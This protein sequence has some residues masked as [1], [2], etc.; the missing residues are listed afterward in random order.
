VSGPGGASKPSEFLN[1]GGTGRQVDAN[2]FGCS[3][4]FLFGNLSPGSWTSVAGTGGQCVDGVAAGKSTSRL[5]WEG[6]CS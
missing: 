3:V 1:Y 6:V 2:H 4:T 5:I